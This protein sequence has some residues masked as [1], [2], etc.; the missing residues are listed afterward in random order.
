M[1]GLHSGAPVERS[2]EDPRGRLITGRELLERVQAYALPNG[3]QSAQGT[4]LRQRGE[5]R[6]AAGR[7]WMPFTA[8]QW[9]D[10]ADL[11]FRWV[12]KARM[13]RLI[14]V[15]VTDAFE[16]GHGTFDVRLL[17]LPIQRLPAGSDTDAGEF[18]RLIAELPWCPV[19]YTHPDLTWDAIDS[20]T[21]RVT[22]AH[23]AVRGTVNF[24]V[25]EEG[26]VL[27]ARAEC[28]GRSVGKAIVPTPW[29]GRY[30]DYKDYGGFRLPS[31]AEVFWGPPE[32]AYA[33]VR[34]EILDAALTAGT[35]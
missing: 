1:I 10:A 17:G 3:L 30:D 27:E 29:W 25:D 31:I 18:L 23:R 4:R 13:A 5:I 32:G 34:I 21:L 16:D 28:R 7:P 11:G 35:P 9:V 6:T 33:Y 2:P 26:R 19:A 22:F 12:A 14:P 8:E 20:R 15:T 24:L